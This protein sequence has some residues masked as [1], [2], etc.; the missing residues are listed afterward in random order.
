[1]LST[2]HD[3]PLAGQYADR[4]ALLSRG[5]IVAEG[6]PAVLPVR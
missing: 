3:L 5:R 2:L 6:S 1:V 4:P